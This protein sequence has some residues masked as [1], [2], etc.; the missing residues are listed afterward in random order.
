MTPFLQLSPPR[1]A[2]QVAAFMRGRH[3][4]RQR[5]L[6][7]LFRL[8]PSFGRDRN[9]RR[10]TLLILALATDNIVADRPLLRQLLRETHRSY[11]LGLSWDIRDAV[12]VL[13]YLLYRHLHCRDIPLLWA[14]RH[15]G[16]SDTYYS[17]D[18][19][20]TFSFDATDGHAPSGEEATAS[21][22]RP[23]HG[24]GHPPLPRT[25]KTATSAVVPITSPI[26]P[27]SACR[28]TWKP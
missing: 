4:R 23:R 14:A 24:S 28:S 12:A 13:T 26:S 18:A 22:C 10:R 8:H 20:I 25:V 19:E 3:H 21:P 6:P 9:Y 5:R 11:T 7:S 15:S 2:Q 1:E 16:G 27:P 17:L